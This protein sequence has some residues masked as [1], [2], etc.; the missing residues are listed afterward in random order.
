MSE[1]F[2]NRCNQLMIGSG[3]PA[4]AFN[5]EVLVYSEHAVRAIIIRVLA[6]RKLHEIDGA[7]TIS[8]KCG[9]CGYFINEND[10][11]QFCFKCGGRA[12]RLPAPQ[13][14]KAEG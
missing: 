3:E 2:Y 8:P 5:G 13:S 11:S 7:V 1:E 4:K 10:D 9:A 14:D 6:D 12:R